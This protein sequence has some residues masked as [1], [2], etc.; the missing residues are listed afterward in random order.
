MIANSRRRRILLTTLAA[1]IWGAGLGVAWLLGGKPPPQQALALIREGPADA[2]LGL[3]PGSATERSKVVPDD[4]RDKYDPRRRVAFQV[5][6]TQDTS[7]F[8]WATGVQARTPSGWKSEAEEYRGEIWRLKAGVPREVCVES[9]PSYAWR[10]YVRYGTGM[11]GPAL[12]RAQLREAWII[13]S[14]TN[15]TGKAWGGGRWS[16]SYELWSEEVRE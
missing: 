6:S 9:P 5:T 1:I 16:G 10:A 14:F 13:R 7:I 11:K 2:P 4:L 15:W 12:L 3:R 8:V